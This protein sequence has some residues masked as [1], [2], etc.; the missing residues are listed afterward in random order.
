MADQRTNTVNF[1]ETTLSTDMGASDLTATVAS[2]E[3]APAPPTL[4]VIEP[5][6]PTRREVVLFDETG[7]STTLVTS[8]LANRYLAGSAAAE[9]IV[10][11]AG[12]VVRA[13]PLAQHFDEL[14]DRIDADR[15][16]LSALEAADVPF[17]GV[18]VHTPQGTALPADTWTALTWAASFYDTAGMHAGSALTVPSAGYWEMHA[19]AVWNAS[20][21]QGGGWRGLRWAWGGQGQVYGYALPPAATGSTTMTTV[22]DVRHLAEGTVL[23]VE[24]YPHGVA[25]AVDTSYS[26]AWVKRV[27]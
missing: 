5:T 1:Y 10:H 9:G 20:A 16:R 2:A 21:A 24:A 19:A 17:V 27:A 6:S 22:H 14:H 13:S 25:S 23:R 11:P 26:F 4:L 8:A 3:E 15:V 7:S 12:S 18:R